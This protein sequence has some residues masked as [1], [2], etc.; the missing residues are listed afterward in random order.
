MASTIGKQTEGFT[1]E[2]S[3]QHCI[4]YNLQRL[5]K[6]LTVFPNRSPE[7]LDAQHRYFRHGRTSTGGG[8]RGGI[9]SVPK[10]VSLS[11]AFCARRDREYEK[12][13][14]PGDLNSPRRALSL[15]S[16]TFL[17]LYFIWRETLPR[18]LPGK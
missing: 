5:R 12:Y 15:S 10:R 9:P 11:S 18:P 7:T 16:V 1:A 14:P 2:Y 8:R 6:L 13:T 17:L 3:A 4:H